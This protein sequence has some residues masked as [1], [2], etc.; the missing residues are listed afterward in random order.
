VVTRRR[1]LVAIHDWDEV[2]EFASEADEADWWGEHSLG[3]ELLAE[4]RPIRED[5]PNLPPPRASTRQPDA[6]ARNRTPP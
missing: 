5:D 4:M 6:R 3:E 2:P 1:R